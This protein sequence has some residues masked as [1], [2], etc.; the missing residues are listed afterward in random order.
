MKKVIHYSTFIFALVVLVM[1]VNTGC[2]KNDLSNKDLL[3]SHPW[4]FSDA[5]TN[6]TDSTI[7]KSVALVKA[8]MTN[9]VITFNADGTYTMTSPFLN[10]PETGTWELSSDEKHITMKSDGSDSGD[11]GDYMRITRLNDTEL[12]LEMDDTADDGTPYT[13]TLRWQK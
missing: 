13:L 5:T 11:T 1:A 2:S 6:S 8:F 4:K 10:D 12:V 3:T 7:I 9:S